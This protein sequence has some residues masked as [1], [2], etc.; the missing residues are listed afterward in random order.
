MSS[1]KH[2]S[3]RR[4]GI[5]PDFKPDYAYL[6]LADQLEARI[7]SVDLI[8]YEQLPNENELANQ[9]G[10]SLGTARTATRVLRERGLVFT[11]RSKGT[12]VADLT[13][14]NTDQ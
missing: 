7:L 10:V 13:L 4:R 12:F 5:G 6:H 2:D 3:G 11:L 14:L 9:Y 1:K 8:R